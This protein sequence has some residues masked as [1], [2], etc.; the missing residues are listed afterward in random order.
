MRDCSYNNLILLHECSLQPYY[1]KFYYKVNQLHAMYQK[2]FFI[3]DS[4]YELNH[5]IIHYA[6]QMN[7]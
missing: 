5:Q 3:C 7:K 4:P 1:E 6:N 2:F